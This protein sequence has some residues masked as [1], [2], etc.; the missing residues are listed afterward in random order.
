[1]KVNVKGGTVTLRDRLDYQSGH[2]VRFALAVASEEMKQSY[3]V[4]DGSLPAEAIPDLMATIS[5]HEILRGIESWNGEAFAGKP[6]TRQ[7]IH[8]L[9][10]D[11]PDRST[12]VAAAADNLYQEQVIG[13]LVTLAASSSPPSPTSEPTSALNGSSSTSEDGG[14]GS[15]PSPKPRKRSKPSS[16][17]STP[18][19][20]T[21]P[22][23]AEPAG[24]S[25]S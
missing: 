8:E 22:I 7:N 12:V 21:E 3:G 20:Y 23:S 1:M 11:D 14:N 13:P 25:R 17:T 2:A 15:T 9:I 24:V 19:D 4:T 16:T 6:V 18:M 5:L 10:L